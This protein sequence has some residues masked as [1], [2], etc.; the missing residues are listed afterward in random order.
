MRKLKFRILLS[1]SNYFFY[2]KLNFNQL[3]LNYFKET[4]KVIYFLKKKFF[5]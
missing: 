5:L 1:Y 3:V 4:N 2:F